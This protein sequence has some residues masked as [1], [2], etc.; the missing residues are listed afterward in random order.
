MNIAKT[1]VYPFYM[2]EF[3]KDIEEFEREKHVKVTPLRDGE[4]IFVDA[5]REVAIGI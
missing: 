1:V 5:N 4:G 2:D 3:K